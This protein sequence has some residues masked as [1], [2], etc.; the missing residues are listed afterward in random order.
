MSK[1]KGGPAITAMAACERALS[2]SSWHFSWRLGVLAVNPRAGF[3]LV[4]LLTVIGII[5]VLIALLMPALEKVR[6]QSNQVKCLANLR[7]IGQAAT[8]HAIEH[9]NYLPAAGWQWNC[10]NSVTDP[11]GLQDPHEKKY[12]YYLDSGTKRPMP[13]TCSL[14][15]Y[16]GVRVRTDSREHLAQ[17]MAQDNLRRLFRCPSQQTEYLGWTEQGD[18]GGSWIAPDEYSSYAFNEALLG[19]RP[20]PDTE[21]CAKGNLSRVK[22]SSKVFFAL[23]GRPRDQSSNRYFLV[24]DF[25]PNDTLFDFQQRVLTSDRGQELLDFARH[26][27][28]VNVAFCDGHGETFAMGLPPGG[29]GDL[30]QIYV[31]RGIVY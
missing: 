10:V 17:D 29:G 30:N 16:M 15:W 19:R 4:E 27:M 22:E 26:R 31:T 18:E 7:S 20:D 5:A 14:A 21:R 13:T 25:S 2:R 23:D 1:R 9:G 24:F 11:A 12:M 6:E 8:M 28:R 3:S